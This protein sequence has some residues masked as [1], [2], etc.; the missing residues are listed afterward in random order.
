MITSL[1]TANDNLYYTTSKYGIAAFLY[2]Y[3]NG[4]ETKLELPYPSG[5][6]VLESPSKES[7]M[8]QVGIDGWTHDYTR[9]LFMDNAF[10]IDP[11]SNHKNYPEFKDIEVNEVLVTS[12][13]GVEVPLSIISKKGMPY[14]GS[15]P[16]FI[17][18]YGAYGDSITPFF[19]PVFLNWVRL[20]GVLVIPHI[21]GGGEKGDSWHEDGMKSKKFNSWKDIIACTEYLIKNKF[22]SKDK[23]VLYSSSAGGIAIGMAMIERP[24][25]FKV[26][27]ADAPMLNPLRSEERANNASNYLEYGTVNDSTECMALIKI[28]PYVNLKPNTEY[29]ATLVI[30]GFNDAR[31]D[32]WMPGKFVAKLQAYSTSNN[33]VFLDVI[34]D[35]GHEGGDTIDEYIDLYSRLFAFAFWQTNHSL[36]P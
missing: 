12:H 33:P 9:Y 31:I 17:Y 6:I 19:S 22:I 27:I 15:N 23:T 8:L 10:T 5:E 24:D 2:E 28:D 21:R 26:F 14:D 13:D 29:P 35:A 1:Y 32:P 34:Y 3:K 4:T 25:L 7:L 20:G 11:L 30:S 36:N 18:T 16:T